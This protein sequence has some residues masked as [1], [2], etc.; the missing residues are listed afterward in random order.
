MEKFD[1]H[2][3]QIELSIVLKL[4][5]LQRESL[6]GLTYQNLEDVLYRFKWA[7]R[8]PRTLHDAVNDILSLS[9]DKIVQALSKLAIIDGYNKNLMDFSDLIGGEHDE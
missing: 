7:H 4:Q 9:A 6:P 5:Q 8:P 1:I 3:S 2:N